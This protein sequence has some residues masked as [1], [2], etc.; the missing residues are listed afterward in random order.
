MLFLLLH[1]AIPSLFSGP[2]NPDLERV[3]NLDS[4][5]NLRAGH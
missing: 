4:V 1:G 5:S 2:E 3:M